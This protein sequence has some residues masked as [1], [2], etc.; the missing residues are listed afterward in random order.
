MSLGGND[1]EVEIS[2]DKSTSKYKVT[3]LDH[4]EKI[5]CADLCMDGESLNSKIVKLISEAIGKSDDETHLTKKGERE[6]R[7]STVMNLPEEEEEEHS[8]LSYDPLKSKE[9]R[10]LDIGYG[11]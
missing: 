9:E 8:E 5:S 10:D 7:Q 11:F 2:I 4:G 1:I 3:I 6:V